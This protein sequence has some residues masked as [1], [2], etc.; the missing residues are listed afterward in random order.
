MRQF[1]IS[2]NANAIV[3]LMEKK[4]YG[5]DPSGLGASIESTDYSVET[6]IIETN[7]NVRYDN[8]S[9]NMAFGY[10]GDPYGRMTEFI[11]S[12]NSSSLKL[13]YYMGE[14]IL[15]ETTKLNAAK[16]LDTPEAHG[17]IYSKDVSF[18]SAS[19][20]EVDKSSGFLISEL[21]LKS[22][23]PW[24]VWEKFPD[25]P[26]TDFNL[27]FST[28]DVVHLMAG[29]TV[30]I[31]LI[32]KCKRSQIYS[33]T[34]GAGYFTLDIVDQD[35]K[36]YGKVKFETPVELGYTITINSDYKTMS[37]IATKAGASDVNMMNYI[38][39]DTTGFLRAPVLQNKTLYLKSNGANK[40]DSSTDSA[41]Y[42][43]EMIIV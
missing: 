38:T 12:I 37:A 29:S 2:K 20:G 9:F 11:R 33:T 41:Y 3:D 31:R 1:W 40:W 42:R 24:Y 13:H 39:S 32:Y 23:S 36:S 4:A 6:D 14:D 34:E 10:G 15:S 8:I 35:G 16:G 43:K 28:K 21:Q 17:D 7:M 22:L 25:H 5:S 26:G 30:P 18:Q 27:Q 19:K